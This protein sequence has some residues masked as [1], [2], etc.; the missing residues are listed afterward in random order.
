MLRLILYLFLSICSCNTS[1]SSI[2]E[3]MKNH[4]IVFDQDICENNVCPYHVVDTS[5]GYGFASISQIHKF[6]GSIIKAHNFTKILEVGPGDAPFHYATH[7]ID[8]QLEHWN[9]SGVY[10]WDLDMDMDR[11]PVEDGYFDFVYCRHVLEDLNNPLH[12]YNE[13]IRVAR[14]GYI[15]TPSPIVEIMRLGNYN[16]P[17]L[18]YGNLRGYHH[19]R[20]LLWTNEEN[21]TLHAVAKYPIVDLYDEDKPHFILRN[22]AMEAV[23]VELLTHY[24]P[25]WNNYYTWNDQALR[26][27]HPGNGSAEIIPPAAARPMRILQPDVDYEFQDIGSSGGYARV[28]REGVSE[29]ITHTLNYFSSCVNY[30]YVK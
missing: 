1:I 22:S 5:S 23:F 15:E 17:M 13:I 2:I 27:V 8:H 25:L 3:V 10:A 16:N 26:Y 20:F 9:I 29:S 28:I 19:H 30:A 7:V 18:N 4:A 24:T 14:N 12:A 21:N 6:Y 11:I